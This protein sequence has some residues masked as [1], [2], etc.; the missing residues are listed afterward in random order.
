MSKL[1]ELYRLHHL[2]D[3]RRTSIARADLIGVHGFARS[4]LSR[5][6]RDLRDTLGA[7]LIYDSE[8]GGYRYETADGRHELPGLWFTAD[9]L[10]ALVTFKHLLGELVPGLLDDHLRPIHTRI[11]RILQN[12]HLGTD[13]V[14]TRVRLI[15]LAARHKNPRHFQTVVYA[16]LQRQRLVI[17]YYN[18]ER[19]QA[20][21]REVSPQRVTHYR[22]NWYLDAWCHQRKALR[23]FAIECIRAASHPQPHTR[24]QLRHLRWHPRRHCRARL[25]RQTRTLGRRRTMAPQATKPLARRRAIRTAR[26]VFGRSRTGH[27][28][29]E[30]WC[31]RRSRRACGAARQDR[32]DAGSRCNAVSARE[33][34]RLRN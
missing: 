1:D 27:G 30:I 19:D 34:A 3:G 20:D 25:Q 14:S 4:T 15:G 10:L 17:D 8:R 23:V 11:D 9:E 28:Y 33:S 32:I 13:E 7:P 24:R 6:I 29:S 5:L 21:T 26:A 31:G 22:D 12:R 16:V 18:R 2:L